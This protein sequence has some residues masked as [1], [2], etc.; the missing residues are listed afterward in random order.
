MLENGTRR[1]DYPRGL[2]CS[3]GLE[4]SRGLDLELEKNWEQM[5]E[6]RHF[7]TEHAGEWQV[8]NA[9]ESRRL[10]KEEKRMRSEILQ[11]RRKKYGKAG[12]KKLTALEEMIVR[13]QT[14]RLVELAEVGQNIGRKEIRRKC[15]KLES[16]TSTKFP[17]G[18]K[19][20]P[21]EPSSTENTRDGK[22][23]QQS[24]LEEHWERLI[25]SKN[26]IEKN[27]D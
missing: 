2:D 9:G 1:L 27:E 22:R 6:S 17:E 10:E 7:L 5:S 25:S 13:N 26:Y 4:Y 16:T 11:K 18:W 15:Q 12:M 14:K 23:L 3:R 8:L 19:C 21:P 20:Q 24:L